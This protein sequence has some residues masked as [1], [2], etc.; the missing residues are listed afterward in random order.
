[1]QLATNYKD[2]LGLDF[3]DCHEFCVEGWKDPLHIAAS[4]Q[5]SREAR[6]KLEREQEIRD[7]IQG[8]SIFFEPSGDQ[9]WPYS[10]PPIY[11]AIA[12]A[13]SKMTEDQVEEALSKLANCKLGP[14]MPISNI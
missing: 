8:K 5:K 7:M 1:M 13:E 12:L 11:F 4:S 2:F 6:A 14:T 9:G 3:P 10:K